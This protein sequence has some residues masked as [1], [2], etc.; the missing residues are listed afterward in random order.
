MKRWRHILLGLL[1]LALTPALYAANPCTAGGALS[2]RDGNGQGGTGW[3]PGDPDGTGQGGT[4]LSLGS[5]SDGDGSGSGGTGL[6]VEVEGVITGFASICVNG[7][8]LHY[9]PSTLVTLHGQA[10]T[11]RELA[12]G[13]VVHA[14]A[15]GRGDQLAV[16]RVQVRHVMVAT[17]QAINP[18]SQGLNPRELHVQGRTISL[19]PDAVLSSGLAPGVKVAVS[20]FVGAHGQSVATRLDVV[21]GNTPDSLTGEVKRNA[22][23]E[24]SVDGVV[25]RGQLSK[26]EPGDTVRAEGHFEQGRMQITR[27]EREDRI[28]PVDRIVIQ[29][30][31]RHADK[32]GL[33]IGNQRFLIDADTRIKQALP[34]AGE[35]AIIDA[36]REGRQFHAREVET[37]TSPGIDLDKPSQPEDGAARRAGHDGKASTPEQEHRSNTEV[38]H[39]NQA[40]EHSDRTESP[41]RTEKSES[42]EKIERIEKPEQP[43]TAE[44][45]ETVERIER[46]ERIE[47]V[48]RPERIERIEKVE[49]PEK[50]ELPERVERPESPAH[51]D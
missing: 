45:P 3:Y 28:M 6:T 31:I 51:G 32:S 39:Q 33:S 50:I 27:V 42:P 14:L 19:S 15:R 49:R 20:G 24:L 25:L 43:E 40:A 17:I 7:L 8:E 30:S 18:G 11:I 34:H 37:Q 41:E 13:Q 1:A 22:E 48:E 44:R 38:E 23:G 36:V 47:T 5:Q 46:V 4:G 26:L 29:G 21:P 2:Q 35:W 10:A 16:Q 9:A 12:V